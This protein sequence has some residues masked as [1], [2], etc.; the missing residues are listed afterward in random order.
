MNSVRPIQI[1]TSPDAA[2]GPEEPL[3][4]SLDKAEEVS[5]FVLT[6]NTDWPGI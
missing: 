4:L 6:V 1:Q 3:T 5:L 2:S